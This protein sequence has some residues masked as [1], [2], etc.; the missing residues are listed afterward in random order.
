MACNNNEIK[1]VKKNKKNKKKKTKHSV[2]ESLKNKYA[3][4]K[5]SKH[6]KIERQNIFLHELEDRKKYIYESIRINYIIFTSLFICVILLSYQFN[7]SFYKNIL[8]ILFGFFYLFISMLLGWYIHYLAHYYNGIIYLEKLNMNP[9]LK[10]IIHYSSLIV[11][12]FHSIIHHDTTINKNFIYIIGEFLSNLYM[13]GGYIIAL[14]YLCK[15]NINTNVFWLWAFLYA[16]VHNINYNLYPP[17]CHIQHHIDPNTNLGIDT[18]DII[19]GTKYDY[20]CLENFN[21]GT[22]NVFIITG[23][24]LYLRYKNILTI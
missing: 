4:H 19:F 2:K 21:H 15:W 20:N 11:C 16:S 22:I 17:E 14:I 6:V 1:E 10:N 5:Y 8:N 24:I 23:L 18:L 13:E 3:D 7:D 12:D 9:I